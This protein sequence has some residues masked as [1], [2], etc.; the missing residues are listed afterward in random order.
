M[1]L[2]KKR[3]LLLATLTENPETVI[4][5]HVLTRGDCNVYM[6]GYQRARSVAVLQPKELPSE[7]TGFGTDADALWQE[8]TQVKDWQCI[9]VDKEVALPLG[10]IISRQLKTP[11]IFLDDVYHIPQGPVLPFENESVRRLMLNDLMLLETLPPEAQP[12]GF[13]GDLRTSLTEGLVAGAVVESKVVATSF[14]AARGQQY[15]DIGV[16]VLENYRRRGLGTAVASVVARS[17]QS[18]GLIPVWGCGSHNLPSLKLARKLGFMEV[19]KRTYV[20]IKKHLADVLSRTYPV[21]NEREGKTFNKAV[22]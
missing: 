3:D 16:Y 8:L 4:S 17:V 21:H 15:V 5:I 7:P 6:S 2:D 12:I 22:H 10:E 9:L 18:D 11:V 1:M 13:W 14:V 20:I 19:S